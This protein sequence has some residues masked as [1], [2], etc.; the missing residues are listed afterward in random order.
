[1]S[2]LN[3]IV[4]PNRWHGYFHIHMTAVITLFDQCSH[5][6]HPRPDSHHHGCFFGRCGGAQA[7][8]EWV[9]AVA[10]FI[11]PA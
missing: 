3:L 6:Q 9:M 7:G 2:S 10:H 1:M 5:A 11:L 4:H 8:G